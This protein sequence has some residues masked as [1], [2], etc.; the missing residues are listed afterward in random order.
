VPITLPIQDLEVVEKTSL[1]NNLGQSYIDFRQ[2]LI[3]RYGRV[4]IDL[5]G[6]YALLFLG[7]WIPLL[8]ATYFPLLLPY[9]VLLSGISTGYWIAY[10]H[11]FMHEAAHFNVAPNRKWNDFISD[12]FICSWSGQNTAAYRIIHWNHHRF[13]G[14]PNDTEH[15]YFSTLNPRFLILALTGIAALK[16]TLFRGKNLENEKTTLGR[17]MPFIALVLNSLVIGALFFLRHWPFAV[18]WILG[19]VVFFPFFGALRQLL[20][21]RSF[22]ADSQVDYSKVPH[23]KTSR[24][25][26][27][28]PVN[29]TFGA[30]G[31]SLHLLHHWDPQVSYTRLVEVEN[32]LKETS[33]GEGIT[34]AKTTY[35]KTF[36]KLFEF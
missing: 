34:A 8:L 16:V 28:G 1:K 30:A 27:S 19:L 22:M 21:H 12:F 2:N 3:P 23:G 7:V 4:A 32:F 20:E 11:L 29:S 10:L 9:L 26:S 24:L 5:L 31:F 6:G 36:L 25:F 18:A 15:S 13:L 17:L 35:F 33:L 14:Q